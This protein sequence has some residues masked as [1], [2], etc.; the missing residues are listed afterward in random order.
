MWRS[1]THNVGQVDSIAGVLFCA[2]ERRLS[3]P[4]GRFLIHGVNITFPGTDPVRTEK[5]L[6]SQLAVLK[7]D[8]ETI[9]SIL[10]TRTGK[11]LDEVAEDM[12]NEVILTAA[13]AQDYGFVTEITANVFDPSQEIVQIVL[14]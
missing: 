2:G 7:K 12:F 11:S 8:R 10:A 4:E 1:I 5:Q 13:E 14:P 9:A 3:V 6:E